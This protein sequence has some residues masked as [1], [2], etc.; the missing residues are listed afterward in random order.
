MVAGRMQWAVMTLPP[1]AACL[2]ANTYSLMS[3]LKFGWSKRRTTKA[4]RDDYGYFLDVL[5]MNAGRG[6]LPARMRH[7][8]RSWMGRG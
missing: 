2:L 1:G 6:G 3:G 8:W 4:E 7:L 5:E